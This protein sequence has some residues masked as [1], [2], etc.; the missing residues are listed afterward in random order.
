MHSY[1]ISIL[2]FEQDIGLTKIYVD[3]DQLSQDELGQ[4]HEASR[5]WE[6]Q[7][8]ISQE[9]RSFLAFIRRIKG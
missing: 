9:I 2:V 4:F 8:K 1:M 6:G 5:F 7:R 3:M